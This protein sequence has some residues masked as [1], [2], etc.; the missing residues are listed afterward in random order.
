MAYVTI[1]KDLS[2]VQSK[3]WFNKIALAHLN[4]K[5]TQKI[6]KYKKKLE[7]LYGQKLLES[8][9]QDN[10]QNSILIMLDTLSTTTKRMYEDISDIRNAIIRV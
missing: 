5:I 3:V 8:I 4:K 1:P 9:I 2:K 10:Q 7:T 6:L